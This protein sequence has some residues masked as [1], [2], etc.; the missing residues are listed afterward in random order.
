MH[1]LDCSLRA[2]AVAA[3][4]PAATFLFELDFIDT[5]IATL[6]GYVCEVVPLPRAL[7][8]LKFFISGNFQVQRSCCPLPKPAFKPSS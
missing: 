6:G 2:P 7:L 1:Q 3:R 4:A 5:A 8:Q